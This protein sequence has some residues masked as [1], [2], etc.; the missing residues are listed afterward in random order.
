MLRELKESKFLLLSFNSS[1]S[2]SWTLL[3]KQ[4]LGGAILFSRLIL[5][6]VLRFDLKRTWRGVYGIVEHLEMG[7]AEDLPGL[8][9]LCGEVKCSCFKT[10]RKVPSGQRPLG[11]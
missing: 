11:C 6:R 5:G 8:V 1:N 3:K 4:V 9:M 2:F 10:Y 7:I